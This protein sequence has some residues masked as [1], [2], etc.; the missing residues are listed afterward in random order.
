[1]REEIEGKVDLVRVLQPENEME[2]AFL[3]QADFV[4]GLLWG[5]PRYGH[6]EGQIYKHVR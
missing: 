3:E 2:A 6:P 1:M 4:K 5:E